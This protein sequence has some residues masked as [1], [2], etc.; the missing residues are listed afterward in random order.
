VKELSNDTCAFSYRD[1]LFKHNEGAQ[2]VV[3]AVTFALSTEPAPRLSYR[4]L[5]RYFKDNPQATIGE[6][7]SAVL[8]IRSEKFP[9]WHRL[10]TAGSF[11][12]NPIIEDKK[13]TELLQ[14][15]P[16]LPHF[17]AGEGK[18][19]VSLSWI[20]DHVLHLKGTRNGN[21]GTYEH[22]VLVLVNYGN[23]TAD[24]IAAFAH[25]VQKK[26]FDAVGVEIEWEVTFVSASKQKKFKKLF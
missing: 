25:D 6:I 7:R 18:V 17:T 20:L 21:V 4:D 22:H 3:L 2:Y 9:D 14:M 15:Y 26:V 1:S 8:T 12:K 19:K 16:E 24:L 5:S 23:A 10:G 11:F 13:C